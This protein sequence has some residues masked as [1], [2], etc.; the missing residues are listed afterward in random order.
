MIPDVAPTALRKDAWL[1]AHPEY[2][3]PHKGRTR[4]VVAPALGDYGV[5]WCSRAAPL[6]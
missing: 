4:V 6:R 2:A 3:A 5:V 1:P